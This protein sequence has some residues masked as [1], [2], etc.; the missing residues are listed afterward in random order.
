MMDAHD[1]GIND[2]EEWDLSGFDSREKLA[3]TTG[4]WDEATINAV[5]AAYLADKWQVEPDGDAWLNACA[6]YNLGCHEGALAQWDARHGAA[7]EQ[8]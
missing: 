5:G 6:R 4:G 7:E 3:A 8:D 1:D 2:G